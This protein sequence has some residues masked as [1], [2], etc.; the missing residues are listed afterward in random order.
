MQGRSPGIFSL[1]PPTLYLLLFIHS[2]SQSVDVRQPEKLK[3]VPGALS[4]ALRTSSS[5]LKKLIPVISRKQSSPGWQ[6]TVTL[7]TPYTRAEW[8]AQQSWVTC[9]LP[10]PQLPSPFGTNMAPNL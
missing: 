8:F 3:A 9:S 6:F 4:F 2:F 10:I 1:S 5:G 7:Q